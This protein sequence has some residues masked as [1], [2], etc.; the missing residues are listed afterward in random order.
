MRGNCKITQLVFRRAA[1]FVGLILPLIFV[2][3]AAHGAPMPFENAGSLT[4]FQ[5]PGMADEGW[6]RDWRE[7]MLL[8]GQ[9]WKSMQEFRNSESVFK[10]EWIKSLKQPAPNIKEYSENF[11]Q[12]SNQAIEKLNVQRDSKQFENWK[13]LDN[14]IELAITQQG[15]VMLGLEATERRKRESMLKEAIVLRLVA[16]DVLSKFDTRVAQ[17]NQKAVQGLTVVEYLKDLDKYQW[18]NSGNWKGNLNNLKDA[19]TDVTVQM[20]IGG[21]PYRGPGILPTSNAFV[22]DQTGLRSAI[23]SDWA[24]IFDAKTKKAT[25]PILFQP[26][27]FQEVGFLILQIE[28]DDKSTYDK[29]CTFTMLT[30]RWAVTA[31]HCFTNP[32]RIKQTVALLQKSD[33]YDGSLA[34]CW[35]NSTEPKCPYQ[36]GKILSFIPSGDAEAKVSEDV[37]LMEVDFAPYVPKSFAR[38][39]PSNVKYS[40]TVTVA[41]YGISGL[42]NAPDLKL[43]VG[44]QKASVLTSIGGLKWV[45]SARLPGAG[46]C[47]G[48]SGGPVFNGDRFSTAKET[49]YLVAIVS[50]RPPNGMASK[51]EVL[52]CLGG[53]NVSALLLPH[54]PWICKVTEGVALGCGKPANNAMSKPVR[55]L[56]QLSR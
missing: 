38:V 19:A 24:V 35:A 33:Q 30:N 39:P 15:L 48:D 32:S 51:G 17:A 12:F 47:A 22:L 43:N 45:V 37:A 41:G 21:T 46:A 7:K 13:N 54:V 23:Q 16:P 9:S 14:E 4:P 55:V 20:Q 50:R 5:L 18:L 3:A 53:E 56:S 52:D 42:S 27:G 31:G 34:N 26:S 28:G 36:L 11:R 25:I 40:S 2:G 6:H 49:D 29:T 44:W 10:E 8:E 1:S